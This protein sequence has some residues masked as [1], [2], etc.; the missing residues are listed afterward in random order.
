VLEILKT[1]RKPLLALLDSTVIIIAIFIAIKIISPEPINIFSY[2][3]GPI[4]FTTSTMLLIF[5]MFNLYEFKRIMAKGETFIRTIAAIIV[6]NTIL[7]ALYFSL[8]HWYF[9]QKIFFIQIALFCLGSVSLR[10]LIA[11][12]IPKL[13]LPKERVIIIGAGKAGRLIA[14]IVDGE[15]IG[16][17]DDDTS[18]WSRAQNEPFIT[19]PIDQTQQI[20]KE[21]QVKKVIFAINHTA[22]DTLL[23]SLIKLR[24][25]GIIVEDMLSLYERQVKKIPIHHIHN[26]W[27][28]L[29][30]GFNLYRGEVTKRPKRVFD[31]LLSIVALIL[32]SPVMI[33]TAVLIM[34]ES[35]GG[36]IF[37]Q[38]RVGLGEKVITLY[39]FRSMRC[40]SEVAGAQWAQSNDPRITRIGSF[41]RKFR[42]DELPQLWNVIKGDMSIIGPRPEQI[43]FVRELEKLL[44]FY[45]IRHTVKPGITGWAQIMYPYGATVED[46]KEKLEYELYYIK[47]ISLFFDLKIILKTIGVIIFGQ[48]AR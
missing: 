39:K 13:N 33:I 12:I 21:A 37:A 32:L 28:L 14:D 9:P 10:I 43:K 15:V 45:Y 6:A 30:D 4:I 22:S 36:F 24:I 16:F 34:L 38:K 8:N 41:I 3:T 47:N 23:A 1:I 44:P 7:G 26:R 5:Y 29:E 25:N 18:K 20:I 40:D 42:I 46:A 27:L 35:P 48:G 19:G 2:Y 11:Y 17:I 31:L